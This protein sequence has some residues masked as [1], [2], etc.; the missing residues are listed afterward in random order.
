ML[1]P[2]FR[3]LRC[4]W[5]N[6]ISPTCA[7]AS[8]WMYHLSRIYAYPSGCW[9]WVSNFGRNV[10]ICLSIFCVSVSDRC[11]GSG[12]QSC[13]H[14][15]LAL[16][17]PG[18]RRGPRRS[19]SAGTAPGRGCLS[20]D[21]VCTPGPPSARAYRCETR[22]VWR[23]TDSLSSRLIWDKCPLP[24]LWRRQQHGMRIWNVFSQRH[25]DVTNAETVGPFAHLSRH[26]AGDYGWTE[27]SLPD[28]PQCCFVFARQWW[29][30]HLLHP[31]HWP[32]KHLRWQ[33]KTSQDKSDWQRFK[34][35]K[36]EMH[37]GR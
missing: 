18:G 30:L 9:I 4:R 21:G 16:L 8:L 1:H 7:V 14:C 5:R 22:S 25:P 17:S 20:C 12:L 36:I 31:H 19:R 24:G 2:N 13:W 11:V 35:V 28:A 27:A 34:N 33:E 10:C 37:D 15:G 29:Q 32:D 23:S 3:L 26:E 6:R